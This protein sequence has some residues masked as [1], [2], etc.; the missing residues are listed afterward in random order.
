MFMCASILSACMYVHH[1]CAWCSWSPEE[2]IGSP[3]TGI[4]NGC[5]LP[6]GWGTKPGPSAERGKFLAAEPSLQC[7]A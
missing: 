5:E 3:G 1:K 4:G 7:L 2:G 6:G